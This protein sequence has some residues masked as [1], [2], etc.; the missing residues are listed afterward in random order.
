MF[1]SY[2]TYRTEEIVAVYEKLPIR[3]LYFS[4]LRWSYSLYAA[5]ATVIDDFK[6]RNDPP[7]PLVVCQIC[8]KPGYKE[9]YCPN[10]HALG[11]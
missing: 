10:A 6:N 7:L 11:F 5:I 1:K 2:R 8:G 4:L 3:R 9:K